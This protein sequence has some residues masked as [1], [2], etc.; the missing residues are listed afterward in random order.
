MGGLFRPQDETVMIAVEEQ[1]F[2]RHASC[3]IY[4]AY[5]SPE[6]GCAREVS[7]PT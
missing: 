2:E 4:T 3:G 1:A 6:M 7:T 5:T